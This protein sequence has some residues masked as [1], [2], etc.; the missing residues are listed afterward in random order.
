MDVFDN[1]KYEF[2]FKALTEIEDVIAV[3]IF[4]NLD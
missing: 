4:N 3:F 1:N 2:E